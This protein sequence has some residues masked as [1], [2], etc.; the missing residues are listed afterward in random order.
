MNTIEKEIFNIISQV[1]I[2]CP[3]CEYV[4]DDEQY[5]CTECWCE[6]G[7]GKL[8][9]IDFLKRIEWCYNE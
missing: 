6:G 3:D 7:G 2:Y 9:I 5:T 8:N 4:Y 1:E